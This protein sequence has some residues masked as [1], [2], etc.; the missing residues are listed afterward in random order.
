MATTVRT[1]GCRPSMHHRL[2]SNAYAIVTLIVTDHG[3]TPPLIP[4]NGMREQKNKKKEKKPPSSP[5]QRTGKGPWSLAWR[6]FLC[7]DCHH[8]TSFAIISLSVR[9]RLREEVAV[10]T[11]S[12]GRA[13]DPPQT[14][15]A[16]SPCHG[17]KHFACGA[18]LSSLLISFGVA[19]LASFHMHDIRSS[20]HLS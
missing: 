18:L 17:V 4:R 7:S 16:G 20:L 19:R 13:K 12:S 5:S 9:A 1:C 15:Q 8:M 11:S 3:T 6:F 10:G 14:S 2:A